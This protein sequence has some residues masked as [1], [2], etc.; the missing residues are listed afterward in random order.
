MDVRLIAM[1]G[2][3]VATLALAACGEDSHDGRDHRPRPALSGSIRIDGSNTV[4]PL[5]KAIARRFM[6]EHRDV[7]VSVG[8]AGY[9]RGFARLCRGEIDLADAAEPIDATAIDACERG[10]VQWN[11]I[12]IANDAVILILNPENPIRCL[13]TD[14]LLQLWRGVA[15]VTGNWDQVGAT[16]PKYDEGLLA[17]GPDTDTETFAWFTWAV[18]RERGVTRDYNNSLHHNVNT[19]LHAEGDP[20]TIGYVAYSLYKRNPAPVKL[21]AV[22]SGEGCVA[23]S[24]TTI[25][26]GTFKPLSRRLFLYPST[27]ALARPEVRAFLRYYLDHIGTVARRSGFVSL[28]DRQLAAS[29]ANLEQLLKARD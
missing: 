8:R 27:A 5:T 13:T 12:T 22:D 21:L 7:H 11:R 14:Q 6:A 20:G 4:S 17:W 15:G 10:G 18:N 1:I 28:T 19:I 29:K 24:P 9:A 3:L 25:A 23:P 16:V 26:N 2:G